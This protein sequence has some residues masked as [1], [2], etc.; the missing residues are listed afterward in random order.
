LSFGGSQ[1][2]VAHAEDVEGAK[3][4]LTLKQTFQDYATLQQEDT[5]LINKVR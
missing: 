3:L 1:G 2:S 5:D 4:H